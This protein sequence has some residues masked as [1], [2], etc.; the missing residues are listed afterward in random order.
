M[1]DVKVSDLLLH[2]AEQRPSDFGDTFDTLIKDRLVSAIHDKKM[3]IAKTIFNS[4]QEYEYEEV[5]DEEEDLE[6]YQEE[7]DDA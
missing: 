5:G 7:D 1:T 6:D 4:S 2:T 3:E